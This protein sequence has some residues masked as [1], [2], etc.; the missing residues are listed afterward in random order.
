LLRA[1]L[2]V[3][4]RSPETPKAMLRMCGVEVDRRSSPGAFDLEVRR[5]FE[6]K[7]CEGEGECECW[8]WPARVFLNSR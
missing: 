2:L 3:G 5:F 6:D 4:E 7:R 8:S 1:L